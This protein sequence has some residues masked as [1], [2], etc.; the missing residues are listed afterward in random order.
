M[1]KKQYASL[2]ADLIK[3]KRTRIIGPEGETISVLVFGT[4]ALFSNQ[5]NPLLLLHQSFP[6]NKSN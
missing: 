4:G 3:C 1:A 6:T 2:T 5:P